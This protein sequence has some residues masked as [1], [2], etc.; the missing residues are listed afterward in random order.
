MFKAYAEPSKWDEHLPLVFFDDRE[1][2]N[3]TTGFTTFELLYI[4]NVRGPLDIL[5]GQW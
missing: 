3:K 2:P 4:R 1:I 5:K